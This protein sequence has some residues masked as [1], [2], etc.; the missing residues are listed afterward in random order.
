M[1]RIFLPENCKNGQSAD[2]F[3]K[4]LLPETLATFSGLIKERTFPHYDFK[5]NSGIRPTATFTENQGQ[6]LRLYVKD[7]RSSK[8]EI[9]LVRSLSTDSF[10][11]FPVFFLLCY[12]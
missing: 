4:Q 10:Q 1:P 2:F 9:G 5:S 11:G 7:V 8:D 3:F 12:Y 6:L